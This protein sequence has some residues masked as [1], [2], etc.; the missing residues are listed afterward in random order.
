MKRLLRVDLLVM[1]DFG[2]K[3]IDQ[4]SAERFYAL[5]DGRFGHKSIILTSNRAMTDW[6][7]RRRQAEA[8]PRFSSSPMRSSTGLAALARLAYTH[9]KSS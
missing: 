5:V 4:Q 9:T 1:D 6:P 3:T 7:A 8:L 2:F